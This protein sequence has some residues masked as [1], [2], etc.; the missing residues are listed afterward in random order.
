[1]INWQEFKDEEQFGE[2]LQEGTIVRIQDEIY[3]P[4]DEST[5]IK[6]RYSIVGKINESKGTNDEF[7]ED[8]I[9]HF[10]EDFIPEIQAIFLK[11]KN[12]FKSYLEQQ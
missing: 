2:T 4:K 6:I 5:E 7:V 8:G 11:A 9:T 1:M 12:S 10:T 3:S